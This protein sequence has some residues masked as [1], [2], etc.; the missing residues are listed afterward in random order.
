[1]QQDTGNLGATITFRN[2]LWSGV[3]ELAGAEGALP[4]GLGFGPN[5][6][7]QLGV[8]GG[9]TD[10][11]RSPHNSHVDVLARM[12]FVGLALWA[13]FWGSWFLLMFRRSRDGR[14]DISPESRGIIKACMVGV[15]AILVNSYFDPTLEGPQV[16]IWLWTLAGLGLGIV[17]TRAVR[18]Q[19]H[20]V[21]AISA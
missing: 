7:Q 5:L 19:N 1:M 18:R 4:T 13:A 17:A 6:A 15:T 3:L 12:G 2:Q 10:P 20:T 16:A 21:R 11:L 9:A 8:S 14:S